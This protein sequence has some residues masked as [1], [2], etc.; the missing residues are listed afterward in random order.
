MDKSA[1]LDGSEVLDKLGLD[2]AAFA[3]GLPGGF[4]IYEADGDERIL[5]ANRQMPAIFGCAD[6]PEFLDHVG[7]TFPGLVYHEDRMR[8]ENSIWAQISN[9]ET[10][11]IRHRDH[12]TY[13]IQSKDGHLHYIDEYGRLVRGTPFG[14]VFFVFVA[15]ITSVDEIEGA[16]NVGGS[17]VQTNVDIDEL[18]GLPSMHYYHAH[19]SEVLARAAA[20]GT[21][22]VDVYLD[23]DH[24][25]TVN[26]RLGFEGGDQALK[27]VAQVIRTC[28]PGDLVARFSDDHFVL[29]TRREG[30]EERLEELH[31]R[32]SCAVPNLPIE[33]KAGIFELPPDA[34]SIPFAHDRAKVACSSIKGRYDCFWRFYNGSLADQDGFQDYVIGNLDR[35]MTEGWI[36]NYYQPV[37]RVNSGRCCELEALTRWVD[38]VDGVIPP[39]KYVQVLEKT[40]LIHMLDTTVI[41]RA[42]ADI[43]SLLAELGTAVPI[44]FNVSP[45]ALSLVDI[46]T[47]IDETV[48]QHGIP[49][50]L[51]HVEI[52]ESS[53]TEDPALLKSVIHRL[54][55]LGYEV[56]MDDFGSGYSSFNL[57]KDFDFDVLKIDMEFLRDMEGN[58]RAQTIVHSITDLA[59]HLGMSTLV[60]GVET[61]QQLEFL[62][63]V[64]ADFAQGYLFSPPVPRETIVNDF[65][66]RY[67]PEKMSAH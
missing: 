27:L 24:F 30:V 43:Q 21:P 8:V 20:A 34:V 59:H 45:S 28:F 2:P 41:H 7:G 29:V 10:D 50:D 51:L 37:V 23:I 48:Q 17:L 14:N 54:H 36:R 67:P 47:L 4:F 62:R 16:T 35:A 31:E 15:D 18:T 61:E 65:F 6:V 11:D 19:T 9:G 53:I 5:F 12:V 33:I 13:R 42:C 63:N 46:P 3:D 39:A 52:T 57:L 58:S 56:W 1:Y 44:S 38:P 22:M 49:R 66:R 64:G 26:H 25:R 32:V 60:E 40:R 55:K